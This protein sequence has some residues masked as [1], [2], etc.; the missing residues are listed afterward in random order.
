[1]VSLPILAAKAPH[2]IRV[3][4]RFHALRNGGKPQLPGELHDLLQNEKPARVSFPGC[5][6]KEALIELKFIDFQLAKRV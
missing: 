6:A 1:M 4:L 2:Q 5:P 3:L